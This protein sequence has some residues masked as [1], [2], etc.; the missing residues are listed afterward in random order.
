MSLFVTT[1]RDASAGTAI[2]LA[3][4]LNTALLP[5][6]T[7]IV[8]LAELVPSTLATKQL[9]TIARSAALAVGAW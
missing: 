2:V 8:I 1:S 4:V 5:S 6:V 3:N 9:S 7:V